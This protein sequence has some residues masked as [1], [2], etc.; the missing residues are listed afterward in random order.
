MKLEN[1]MKQ[2]IGYTFVPLVAE[3]FGAWDKDAKDEVR[4]MISRAHAHRRI[5][6]TRRIN[7]WMTVLTFAF[8]RAQANMHRGQLR[9]TIAGVA[10]NYE[11]KAYELYAPMD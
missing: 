11:V 10:A 8:S 2:Y 4:Y 9:R 6:I 1:T 3:T 5:D 7:H